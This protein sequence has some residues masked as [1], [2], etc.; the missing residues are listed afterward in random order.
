MEREERG[1]MVASPGSVPSGAGNPTHR[2]PRR[3]AGGPV[4]PRWG[5]SVYVVGGLYI[6]SLPGVLILLSGRPLAIANLGVLWTGLAIGG[7]VFAVLAVL[8][9]HRRR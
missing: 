2:H 5:R 3:R 9:P 4:P 1:M 8:L 6:A 7:L